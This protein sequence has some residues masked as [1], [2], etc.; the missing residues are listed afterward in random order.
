VPNP[1]LLFRKGVRPTVRKVPV[2]HGQRMM[3]HPNARAVRHLILVFTASERRGRG[4]ARGAE[5][6]G[7]M[8]PSGLITSNF[9]A[10]P[11]L[12]ALHQPRPTFC[13]MP[14]PTARTV[15]HLDPRFR[16]IE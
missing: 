12:P 9:I 4:A 5:A 13:M 11:K 3:P 15:R 8:L 2:A 16:L 6:R 7:C 14:R 1:V 10:E